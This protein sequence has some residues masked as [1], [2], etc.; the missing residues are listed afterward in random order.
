MRTIDEDCLQHNLRRLR[1]SGVGLRNIFAY[2]TEG[3]QRFVD[4]HERLLSARSGR[5]TLKLSRPSG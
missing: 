4:T 5:S 2:A 3:L 1:L